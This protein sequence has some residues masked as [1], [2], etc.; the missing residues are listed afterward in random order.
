MNAFDLSTAQDIR[1]G[2]TTVSA[3]Y[4]G[5]TLVWP[6][7]PVNPYESQYFTIEITQAGDLYLNSTGSCQTEPTLISYDYSL[8]NGSWQTVTELKNTIL[9]NPPSYSTTSYIGSFSV[10]DKIR[11]RHTGSINQDDYSRRFEG[12]T[13]FKV[14]G[15]IMSLLYGDSFTNQTS[16]ISQNEFLY[17]FWGSNISHLTDCENL[18]LPATTLTQGCY[19]EMFESST[20]ITKA[21]I[22]PASILVADCYRDMF[23]GCTSLNYVKCYATDISATNLFGISCLD[24]WLYNVAA[25]GT[26]YK[27]SNTTYPSGTSGI[28]SGWTIENIQ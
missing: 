2:S 18:V 6:T 26:F 21:P 8:N 16:L 4:L 7:Q 20:T 5:N 27:D 13:Y 11:I 17:M 1:L 19:M 10:G 3:V 23:N 24:R 25:T 12:S 14:Y 15:N 22:L 28:P 9:S